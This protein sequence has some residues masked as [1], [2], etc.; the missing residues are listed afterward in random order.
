EVDA[1]AAESAHPFGVRVALRHVD[2]AGDRNLGKDHVPRQSQL[3]GTEGEPLLR[4]QNA[5]RLRRPSRKRVEPILGR[6]RPLRRTLAPRQPPDERQSAQ[7]REHRNQERIHCYIVVI[8]VRLELS[9]RA[10]LSA[11]PRI[12]S[13]R[14][15]AS[16]S[17]SCRRPSSSS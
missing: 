6:L 17:S 1:L 11:L 15:F 13:S 3:Q 2:E 10:T 16:S 7:E 12:P 5:R 9:R 4:A 14:P 8:T